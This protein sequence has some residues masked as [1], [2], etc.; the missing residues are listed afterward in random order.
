MSDMQTGQGSGRWQKLM[1]V[2]MLLVNLCLYGMVFLLAG[3]TK[4]APSAPKLVV[5]QSLDLS[6]AYKQA[7]A[8]A[9][10]RQP[11]VQLVSATA[12]W[13]LAAGDRLTLSRPAWS[14]SFY[15][16]ATHQ[17]QV[18]TVDQRGAQA[19]PQQ[20]V[21]AVPQHAKLDWN[22]NSDDLLLTFLSHG[23][24]EFIGSYPKANIHLQLKG[25]DAAHSIW[26]ITAVDPVARQSL[27]VGVDA[28]SRQVVMSK[29]SEGGG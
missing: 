19:G 27:I 12:S 28:F 17:V 11:E 25:E 1:L 29:A 5:D 3:G 9:L 21:D 20:L 7:L 24:E 15:S 2:G 16:P 13:Q 22:V 26:Y 10:S 18:V 6:T 4:S 14:F 23:G 8:L